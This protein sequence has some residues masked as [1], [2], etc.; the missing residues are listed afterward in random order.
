[1]PCKTIALEGMKPKGNLRDLCGAM[2]ARKTPLKKEAQENFLGKLIYI[3]GD[4]WHRKVITYKKGVYS[5]KCREVQGVYRDVITYKKGVY[6][7]KCWEVQGQPFRKDSKIV[8][9]GSA[10][11]Y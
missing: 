8:Q 4:I 3:Q 1:M 10:L 9:I 7:E 11:F 2:L 5:E 6:S